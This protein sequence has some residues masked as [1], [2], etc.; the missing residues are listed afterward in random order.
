MDSM[1]DKFDDT[2]KEYPE[3]EKNILN[4]LEANI[5]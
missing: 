4:S 3:M 2:P 5:Y 1:K